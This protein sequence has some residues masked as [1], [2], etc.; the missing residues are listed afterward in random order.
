MRASLNLSIWP[1]LKISLSANAKHDSKSGRRAQSGCKGNV[2][3]KNSIE[4]AHSAA[5]FYNFTADAEEYSGPTPERACHFLSRL[6][7]GVFVAVNVKIL[8]LYQVSVNLD[9]GH[10]SLVDSTGKDK[11]T[12]IIGVLAYQIDSSG[13]SRPVAMAA[14]TF[15][16]YVRYLLA[17][18]HI[19]VF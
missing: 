15:G 1:P 18:L 9:F 17:Q 10:Y 6:K 19:F 8:S 4:T 7:L 2:T 13:R 5:G 3:G 11:T 14:K 16:E 12:V